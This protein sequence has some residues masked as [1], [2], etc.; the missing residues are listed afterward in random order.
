M[1]FLGSIEAKTDSKGR[2]FF[3]SYIPQDIE[4]IWRRIFGDEE[5]CFSALFG[6]LPSISVE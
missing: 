1:R 4:Y 2:A 6:N 5:R 3:T